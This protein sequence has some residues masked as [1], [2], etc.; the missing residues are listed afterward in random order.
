MLRVNQDKRQCPKHPGHNSDEVFCLETK[1]FHCALCASEKNIKG[2]SIESAIDKLVG[3]AGKESAQLKESLEKLSKRDEK[4]K[5]ELSDAQNP[6]NLDSLIQ[7]AKEDIELTFN[8]L[9]ELIGEREHALMEELATLYTKT[10]EKYSDED[11]NI[12]D[13]LGRGR[14]ALQCYEDVQSGERDRRFLNALVDLSNLAAEAS[15][16]VKKYE[17]EP[18]LSKRIAFVV[19]E[20][21]KLIE[22]FKTIGAVSE[23]VDI[24]VPQS[25][26]VSSKDQKSISLAWSTA[27][28]TAAVA[29]VPV[30]YKVEMKKDTDSND[31]WTECYNGSGTSYRCENLKESTGYGFRIHSVYQGVKSIDSKSCSAQTVK[32]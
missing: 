32:K 17:P 21:E 20:K 16:A 8:Q 2:E 28:F 22:Q 19:D 18:I 31:K 11:S 3:N 7:K 14:D 15:D 12:N 30:T 25:F 4:L 1:T 13:I 27:V 6:N 24:P 5:F 10:S 26:S 23:S 29:S 9:R